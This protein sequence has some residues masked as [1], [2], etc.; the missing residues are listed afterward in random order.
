MPMAPP[1][2]CPGCR[3]LVTARRCPTCTRTT[4]IRRGNSSQRLYGWRWHKARTAF[5]QQHGL[6]I[7]CLKEQVYTVANVVDHQPPHRGDPVKFWDRS[8]WFPR[9]KHHH[10]V[11]TATQDG[12]FG[13]ER[14]QQTGHD[15]T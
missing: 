3:E 14:H 4:D 6:C 7:D 12:G 1:R 11:K 9:C 5:L 13:H 10:D 8:T 15:R 2:R